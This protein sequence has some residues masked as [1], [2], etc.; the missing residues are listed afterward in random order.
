MM[1]VQFEITM[2]QHKKLFAFLD[3]H[4]PGW[5][6]SLRGE[7]AVYQTICDIYELECEEEFEL[8]AGILRAATLEDWVV[9][10][11]GGIVRGE[12][13]YPVIAMTHEQAAICKMFWEPGC[14]VYHG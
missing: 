7:N 11:G 1:F 4:A 2:R 14:S 6:L 3:K 12:T 13:F 10:C 5:K 9:F 8:L